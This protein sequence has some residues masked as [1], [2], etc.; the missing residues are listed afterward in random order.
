MGIIDEHC[1]KSMMLNFMTVADTEQITGLLNRADH[2][3]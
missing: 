1:L 2:G 3:E